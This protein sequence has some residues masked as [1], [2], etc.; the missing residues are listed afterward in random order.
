[1][2]HSLQSPVQ[3]LCLV[4]LVTKRI[5]RPSQRNFYC[6]VSL[7]RRRCSSRMLYKR[8]SELKTCQVS[9][10]CRFWIGSC[11]ICATWW[12]SLT[13]KHTPSAVTRGGAERV[14]SCQINRLTWQLSGF[15]YWWTSVARCHW[16]LPCLQARP[17]VL[18]PPQRAACFTLFLCKCCDVHRVLHCV[19]VCLQ[20]EAN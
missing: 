19:C 4:M 18:P 9:L 5:S 7:H 15:V 16:M 12:P 1:M 3:S 11:G 17:V 20:R 8:C 13:Y 10:C 6:T 14:W 2:W